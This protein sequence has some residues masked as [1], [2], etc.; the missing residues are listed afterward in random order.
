MFY[1][2]LLPNE[3]FSIIISKL[4][5]YGVGTWFYKSYDIMHLNMA[6]KINESIFKEL[7]I[8]LFVNNKIKSNFKDINIYFDLCKI[9]NILHQWFVLINDNRSEESYHIIGKI[10]REVSNDVFEDIITFVFNSLKEKVSTYV[11]LTTLFYRYNSFTIKYPKI[12]KLIIELIGELKDVSTTESVLLD[13][14]YMIRFDPYNVYLNFISELLESIHDSIEQSHFSNIIN[15]ILENPK[16]G[17][18]TK[19]HIKNLLFAK[20]LL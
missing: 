15:N 2:D 11:L 12:Q 20:E 1:F 10:Y 3:I 5:K 4:D 8:N 6:Y 18:L 13:I 17:L 9:K 19:N 14:L 16:V 7:I